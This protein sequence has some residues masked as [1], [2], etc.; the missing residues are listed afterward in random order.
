[1]ELTKLDLALIMA[2]VGEHSML[3]SQEKLLEKSEQYKYDYDISHIKKFVIDTV[4]SS[5]VKSYNSCDLWHKLEE[6][7][8]ELNHEVEVE[9]EY[10]VVCERNGTY[11][12]SYDYYK[13]EEDFEKRNAVTKFVSIIPESKRMVNEAKLSKSI[14]LVL[15]E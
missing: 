9:Y 8:K 6:F 3:R 10:L 2:I 12:I 5:D 7:A 14:K 4:K 11:Q 15:G 13:D 1:M